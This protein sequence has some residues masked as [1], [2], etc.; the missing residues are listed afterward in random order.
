MLIFLKISF[1]IRFFTKKIHLKLNHQK[2]MIQNKFNF[3]ILKVI[4]DNIFEI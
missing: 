4:M 1:Y 2:H 3:D